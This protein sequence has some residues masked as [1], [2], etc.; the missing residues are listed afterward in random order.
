MLFKIHVSKGNI[1]NKWQ[2]YTVV[3]ITTDQN[4]IDQFKMKHGMNVRWLE[5]F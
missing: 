2:S 4:L 3:K 1:E 5:T